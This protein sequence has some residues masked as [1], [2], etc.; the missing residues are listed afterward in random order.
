MV[1]Q[2][3]SIAEQVVDGKP[4]RLRLLEKVCGRITRYV[5]NGRISDV[6]EFMLEVCCG[7]TPLISLY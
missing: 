5:D 6:E 2:L 7:E 3:V 4:P 1:G